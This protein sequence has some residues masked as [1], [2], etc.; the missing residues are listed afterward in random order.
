M[1]PDEA[2]EDL[3]AIREILKAYGIRFYL[4]FGTL[5]GAYRSGS[6]IPWDKDIDIMIIGHSKEK[7]KQLVVGKIFEEHG[8]N[9]MRNWEGLTTV[10]RGKAYIDIYVFSRLGNNYRCKILTPQKVCTAKFMLPTREI[11]PSSIIKFI[12]KEWHTPEPNKYLTRIYG[13]WKTPNK[14]FHAPHFQ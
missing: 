6:F 5:L 14:K 9:V 8:F 13:D 3:L 4:A 10:N 1:D 12:G 2:K 11:N 7:L